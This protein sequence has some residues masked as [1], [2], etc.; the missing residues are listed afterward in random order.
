VR[1]ALA[2]PMDK[3]THVRRLTASTNVAAE[4]DWANASTRQAGAGRLGSLRTRVLPGRTGG[5]T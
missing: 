2:C 3:E 5:T 1:R 4:D